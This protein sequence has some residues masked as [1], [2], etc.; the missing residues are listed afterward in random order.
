[1]TTNA[2]AA[3]VRYTNSGAAAYIQASSKLRGTPLTKFN[4]IAYTAT[5]SDSVLEYGRL[6]YTS[7][8]VQDSLA[9]ATTLGDYQLS[10]RKDPVGRVDSVTFS[11]WDTRITT[12]ILARSIGDSITMTEQHTQAGG[13]WLI[14]GEKHDVSESAYN[15]TWVLEDA[16]TIIYWLI[17]TATQSEI[18]ETTFVGPL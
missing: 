1:M 12:E 7:P 17:G 6:V 13:A 10:L 5:D 9:D 18:G 16:G 14:L 11:G 15:V 3:T 8:G 4:Q 2:T